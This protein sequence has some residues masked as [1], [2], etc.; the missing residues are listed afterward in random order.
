MILFAYEEEAGSSAWTVQTV[1]ERMYER[2]LWHEDTVLK[3]I[4]LVE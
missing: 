1:A 3:E 2:G 4:E